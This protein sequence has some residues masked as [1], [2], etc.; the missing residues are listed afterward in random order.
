MSSFMP[1]LKRSPHDP[2]LQHVAKPHQTLLNVL[3]VPVQFTSNQRSL[4]NLATQAFGGL[5]NTE[6]YTHLQIELLANQDLHGHAFTEPPAY[7]QYANA[8]LFSAIFSPADAVLCALDAHNA[9]ITVSPAM[10]RFPYNV[11]YEMIENAAYHLVGCYLDVVPLHGAALAHSNSGL[12]IFGESGAGKSTFATACLCAGWQL[13]GEDSAFVLP[14]VPLHMRG[15]P[16]FLHL[17]DDALRFFPNRHWRGKPIVRR[18]ARTKLELDVRTHFPQAP[19]VDAP[20]STLIFLQPYAPN[21]A[22]PFLRAL[23][24]AQV[25]RRLIRTQPFGS[26]HARWPWL[27]DEVLKLPAFAL[28]PS[29]DVHQGVGLL[30]SLS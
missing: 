18:S 15:V 6:P 14:H 23:T 13:I 30:A 12:L 17:L 10:R 11:R 26:Q 20:I 28:Y 25:Q 4:L 22:H 21:R 5:Q 7:V 2:F 16:N 19:R 8:H 1:S 29:G 3:G 9:L 27:L 24:P